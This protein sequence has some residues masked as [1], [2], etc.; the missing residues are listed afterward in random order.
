MKATSGL[1]IFDAL[2]SD[3]RRFADHLAEASSELRDSFLESLLNASRLDEALVESLTAVL[4]GQ[5]DELPDLF[6][7]GVYF[8]LFSHAA[9]KFATDGHAEDKATANAMIAKAETRRFV[10]DKYEVPEF[11]LEG[12]LTLYRVGTTSF[13]ISVDEKYA[14][15][16]LKFPY[17]SKLYLQFIRD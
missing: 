12:E 4:Q 3:G 14:L 16:L 11:G 10:S 8:F 15:K 6:C 13:I 7:G 5:R 2:R 1:D 9:E 17:C